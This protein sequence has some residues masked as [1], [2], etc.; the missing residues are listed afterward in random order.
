MLQGGKLSD[1]AVK[2]HKEMEGLAIRSKPNG[3]NNNT[4]GGGGGGSSGNNI[5]LFMEL[6]KKLMTF[7]DVFDVPPLIN[8]SVPIHD[9]CTSTTTP[10]FHFFLGINLI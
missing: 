7:R 10:D 5:L 6:R 2:Q 4:N 3:N 8:A 1:A 9:V